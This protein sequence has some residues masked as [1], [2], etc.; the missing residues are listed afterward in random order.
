MGINKK[1][2]PYDRIAQSFVDNF[3]D[4]R[5]LAK[6]SK[7]NKQTLLN[8]DGSVNR[9]KLDTLLKSKELKPFTADILTPPEVQG[10]FKK[11]YQDARV[12]D[13]TK[14]AQPRKIVLW[15]GKV[16][17][18]IEKELLQIPEFKNGTLEFLFFRVLKEPSSRQAF[19][20]AM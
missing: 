2:F 4:T 15:L 16:F 13:K 19:L 3:F 12:L 1:K 5:K 10:T 9:N 11:L 7:E 8:P 20:T 6:V 18:I 14:K 17:T